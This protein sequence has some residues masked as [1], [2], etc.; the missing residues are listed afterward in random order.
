MKLGFL[1]V[2]NKN[3][4]SLSQYFYRPDA[5]LQGKMRSI[6]QYL[7]PKVLFPTP[8]GP[9]RTILGSGRLSSVNPQQLLQSPPVGS[10]L[11]HDSWA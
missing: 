7:L 4:K 8:V 5:Q 2:T 6:E 10:I 3:I 9:R 1:K 11:S